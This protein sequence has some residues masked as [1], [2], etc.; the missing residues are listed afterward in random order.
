MTDG[1]AE[2]ALHDQDKDFAFVGRYGVCLS[3][4]EAVTDPRI[5]LIAFPDGSTQRRSPAKTRLQA[6]SLTLW[7]SRIRGSA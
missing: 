2:L 1:Y 6:G 7:A 3:H 4:A 5:T